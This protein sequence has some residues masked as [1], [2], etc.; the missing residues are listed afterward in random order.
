MNAIS[1]DDLICVIK[2]LPDGKAAGLSGISNEFWKHC[3]CS[4]LGL[5]LD[6]LNICLACEPIALIETA[7]KILFKLL[8]NRIFSACSLFNILCGDNF[9]VLKGTITQF[10]I[11]AIGLVVKNT[12]E[13]DHEL[14]FVLQ[15][16]H[17]AYNSVGWHHL[18]NSLVWIKMCRHFIR[19][20][21]SIHND[22][23]NWVMTDF[24]LID[25]YWV[26]RQESLCGY[27]I[28][29]KF[30]AKTGRIENQGSL[31]SF[32]A[33]S[34][35]VDDI[36]WVGSSQAATQYILDTRLSKPSL[37]KMHIDVKFFVNLVLK[38]AISNKQFFYLVLAVLQPIISY[39]TQFSFVSRNALHYSFLY[40]LRFFEQLQTEYKV[41][42]VLCF[43]NTNSI[44]GYLF[45]HKS[46]DLQV[47]SWSSIHSL[48]CLIRLYVSLVNNFLAKVIK[49]FL[50]YDMS[51]GN[52]STPISAVLGASL[53]YDISLSLRKF[54]RLDLRGSVPHWF[55]LIWSWNMD[56]CSSGAVSRLSHCFFSANM[57]VVNV[58]TDR[59][60]R[61][62]GSCEIKCG[63]AAYFSDLDMSIGAKV[64][65]LVSLTM[66]KLQAIALALE[67]VLLN[68]SV[69]VYS[70]SQAALDT[71]VAESALM[72][73]DFYNCCWI[74]WHGIVKEHLGVVG[75]KYADKLAG[76]ATSSSLAL[77][78]LVRERFIMA[79]GEAVSG[80]VCHFACKIFRSINW[81]CW[82]VGSGFN[83]VDDSLLGDHPD[84]HMA[85]SFTSK[86]IAGL[87]SYFL[88]AF[89]YHLLVAVR[90]RLYSKVY[91]SVS[92]LHCGE[93]EMLSLCISDDVLYTTMGKDF[94]FRDW[95]QKALSILGD[96]KVAERFIVDFV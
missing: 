92:Y 83:V 22:H 76:L 37:A 30:V 42:S 44:L 6:L 69:V 17:K 54:G 55:T 45:N 2:D 13:K 11:F 81:A 86:S 90:K 5:L 66:A 67:C 21:G 48:H 96:I 24:G 53:F 85:A 73:L 68:S 93:V 88:K 33:A 29:T 58:Y 62:L 82:E 28:N 60:L 71:C 46:L 74:E 61:D 64:G 32:L 49:I 41:A 19:F 75:N 4:V 40:S 16:M 10:P 95:V 38:K 52:L 31:T 25:G 94:V 78:V 89:H 23:I 47:L 34:T 15:D 65:G 50:D 14:W 3:D 35:F 27:Q 91:P 59:L 8:S 9:S 77:P 87:H 51:L 63:A 26:K 20:F 12:L 70:N 57:R 72:S 39:R 7:H 84:F 36:I 56:V 79:T 80:N 43:S 1:L 18:H